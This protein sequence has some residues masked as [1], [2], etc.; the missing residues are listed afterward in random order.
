MQDNKPYRRYWLLH[1]LSFSGA[2]WVEKGAN[3]VIICPLFLSHNASEK[4]NQCKNQYLC[5][6]DKDN[7]IIQRSSQKTANWWVPRFLPDIISSVLSSLVTMYSILGKL[8]WILFF[9]VFLINL[10]DRLYTEI[11][12]NITW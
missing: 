3:W 11:E 7:Q 6:C 12:N 5:H 9:Y 1:W 2:S 8:W 4:D 10:I